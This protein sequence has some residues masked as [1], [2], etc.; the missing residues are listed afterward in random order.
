MQIRPLFN[1]YQRFLL[2]FANTSFGRDYLSLYKWAKIKNNYPIIGVSPDGIQFWTREYNKNG[3]PIC[4]AVFFSKSPYLK[5][6]RLALEGLAIIEESKLKLQNF[7]HNRPEFV[8]PH[9]QGLHDVAWLPLLMRDSAPF[10]SDADPESTSVDGITQAAPASGLSWSALVSNTTDRGAYDTTVSDHGS[11]ASSHP[12][13]GYHRMTRGAWLFDISSLAGVDSID[14]ATLG[15]YI[16]TKVTSGG[17]LNNNLY[18]FTPASNTSLTATDYS[19][20]GTTAY[21]NNIATGGFNTSAFNNFTFVSAGI[22]HLNAQ[23]AS[24]AKICGRSVNDAGVSDPGFATDKAC[25]YSLNY[26]DNG[27]NIPVLTIGYTPGGPPGVKTINELAIASVKTINET[28]I[29]SVKTIQ[30]AS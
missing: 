15:F 12:T 17:N 7:L 21:A 11:R 27:T 2:A 3:L 20:V 10:N 24:V 1:R 23:K 16:L 5:K 26:A 4:Q 25:T 28:A 6:F 19:Q 30:D 8:I 14:S 9:F 18:N 13:G 29:G 22:T